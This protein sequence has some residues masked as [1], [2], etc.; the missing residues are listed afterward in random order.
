MNEV[1]STFQPDAKSVLGINGEKYYCYSVEY[2][3]KTG[4]AY[5]FEVYAVSDKDCLERLERIQAQ[6]LEAVQIYCT[7]SSDGPV[8]DW[9]ARMR[10]QWACFWRNLF[11]V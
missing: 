2:R 4:T 6:K 1:T 5:S 8:S 7:F 11:G 3:D 9:W 10:A